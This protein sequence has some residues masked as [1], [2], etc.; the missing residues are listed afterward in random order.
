MFNRNRP[1]S[2]VSTAH[3]ATLGPNI[4]LAF[5]LST[6]A[7]PPLICV[8]LVPKLLILP[9]LSIVAIASAGLVALF[10]WWA[11]AQSEGDRITFWDVSGTCALIGFAAGMLSEPE[12]VVELLSLQAEIKP[13]R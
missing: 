9:A 8:L 5:L 7:V 10:A 1:R 13:T 3:S 2:H 4:T 11:V 12:H 6:A